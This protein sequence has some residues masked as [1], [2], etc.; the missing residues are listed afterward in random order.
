[1]KRTKAATVTPPPPLYEQ[2]YTVLR[3][4]II[5]GQL[6]VGLVLGETPVA[7]VFQASRVPAGAAL[8]RLMED[9]LITTFEGRGYVIG[10]AGTP[11]LRQDLLDAGLSVPEDYLA[12]RMLRNRR[13][14]IYPDVE[15]TIATCLA[16]GR[17]LVNESALADYYQVSRTVAH[18]VLTRLER[19]GLVS[20]DTNQRWYAGPLTADGLHEHFEVRWLLEPLALEQAMQNTDVTLIRSKRKKLE[21]IEPASLT[22]PEAEQVERDIHVDII[23]RCT[24]QR[25]RDTIWRSQLPIIATHSTFERLLNPRELVLMVED[26]AEILLAMER[27][28]V[29]SAMR[30]MERHLRRS[31]IHNIALL[32]CLDK[33]PEKHQRPYLIAAG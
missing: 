26:H 3:Q 2:I 27:G 8:R 30:S 25:L 12:E 17:F 18:E 5:G 14:H 23:L 16:Y 10:K 6:P 4:Q 15:H 1:M 28:K 22:P 9:G 29:R 11:P 32:D 21:T 24:N 20:Q 19:T 7:R 31:L 13:E 33:L